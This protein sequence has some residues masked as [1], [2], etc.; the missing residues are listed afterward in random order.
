MLFR[1]LV[2][3]ALLLGAGTAAAQPLPS[4]FQVSLSQNGIT[5][6]KD[7]LQAVIEANLTTINITDIHIDK[8]KIAISVTNI[9]CRVQLGNFQASIDAGIGITLGTSNLDRKSVV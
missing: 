4:A 8:D 9:K 2:V 7:I 5:Y 1:V 6:F 3:V